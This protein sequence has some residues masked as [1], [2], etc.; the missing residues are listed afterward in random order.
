MTINLAISTTSYGVSR[1]EH[2]LADKLIYTRKA[3]ARLLNVEDDSV[4][5]VHVAD[6]FILV[7][8]FNDSVKLDKKEFID[9]FV[10]DRK[11][12]SQNMTVTQN[13]DNGSRFTV[14]NEDNGHRYQVQLYSDGVTCQCADFH[15]QVDALGRGCCKHTYATLGAYGFGSLGDYL[16]SVKSE[17]LGNLRAT[18]CRMS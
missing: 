18:L 13:V 9:V 2:S 4:E 10:N 1:R 16:K 15:K 5:F 6:N 17:K 7:G 14:R 12:R 3:A 8:T 11:A